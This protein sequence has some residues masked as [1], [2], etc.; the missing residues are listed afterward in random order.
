MSATTQRTN[1]PKSFGA[2][3]TTAASPILIFSPDPDIAR[4]LTLLLE[5][6]YPVRAETEFG[7][8]E[9]AIDETHAPLM[10]I[11]LYSFPPDILRT[12]DVLSRRKE[13]NPVIVFH[14][15]RNSRPEIEQAV[16]S[17][18]DLILYKP[19]NA[20]LVSELVSVLLAIH[21]SNTPTEEQVGGGQSGG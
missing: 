13:K 11:D 9:Q 6:T 14:V 4:S 10:L 5:E 2:Q 20:E 18:S 1:Q 21:R 19:I 15:F 8:L 17:V 16:R 3:V 7:N 12:V